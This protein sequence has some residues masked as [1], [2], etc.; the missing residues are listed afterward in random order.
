MKDI[1]KGVP[2]YADAPIHEMMTLR[3]RNK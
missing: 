3:T 1:K 2:Q